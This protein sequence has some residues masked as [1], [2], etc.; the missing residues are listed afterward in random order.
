MKDS[1]WM[2]IKPNDETKDYNPVDHGMAN[3]VDNSNSPLAVENS[4]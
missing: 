3:F 2:D 1:A 4:E